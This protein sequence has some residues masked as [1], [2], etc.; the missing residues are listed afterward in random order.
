MKSILIVEG[1]LSNCDVLKRALDTNY[2][3]IDLRC[4]AEAFSFVNENAPDMIIIDLDISGKRG[5]NLCEQLKENRKTCDIPVILITTAT[6]NEDF[7]LGLQVGANDYIKKPLCLPSVISRIEAHLREKDD[8]VELEKKDLRMLLELSE[9]ISVTRSPNAIL[10][11]IVN[12]ISNVLDVERC[13]V[14]SFDEGEKLAVKASSD[15][16][17]NREIELD[18]N[19][20]PEIRKAIESRKTVTI[21]DFKND[22]LMFSVK[23]FIKDLDFNSVIVIPL[24]KKENVIGTFLFRTTSREKD[25][26]SARVCKLCQ[27]VAN[28]AA[29]ALENATLFESVRT[30]QEYFE[31]LS[32]RD[33]LTKIFNRRH[34]YSRLKA[35]FS[36]SSRHKEPL[37]LIFFDIDNFKQINDTYGHTVGDKIL[38]TVGSLLKEASRESDLPARYGG[39]EFV[40]MLP[41]TDTKGVAYLADRIASKI[42]NYKFDELDKQFIKISTG[43]ST[44][45]NENICFFDELIALADESMYQS[46]TQ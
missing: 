36:R 25:W 18:I 19:K 15:L 17:K 3:V 9:T 14:I 24:I 35:E 8:Y 34:F 42:Q 43:V 28:I 38:M 27:L 29:N 32:I 44:Y 22:P 12:K 16:E 30:A 11:L 26:A 10:R 33:D 1:D 4:C 40:I 45:S 6:K 20:Y 46:K 7:I 23:P 31:E 5:V 41:N 21:N 37:S 2:Q 39:D 13:S